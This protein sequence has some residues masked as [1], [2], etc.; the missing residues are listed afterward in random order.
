M[1]TETIS[2]HS[3]V[4]SVATQ[5]CT[6]T[7]ITAAIFLAI[8]A[9]DMA[10]M[11]FELLG[12]HLILG[13]IAT[14]LVSVI[15]QNGSPFIAWVLVLFPFVLLLISWIALETKRKIDERKGPYRLSAPTPSSPVCCKKPAPCCV[16]PSTLQ[17]A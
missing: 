7:I 5:V 1:N 10:R 12:G 17:S 16:N 8:L 13:L 4:N 3:L 6:P 14:L 9:I 2:M 15:C 11:E